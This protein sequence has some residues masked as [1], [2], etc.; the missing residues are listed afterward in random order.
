MIERPGP[1]PAAAVR[2]PDLAAIEWLGGESMRTENPITAVVAQLRAQ[3]ARARRSVWARGPVVRWASALGVLAVLAALG[4][5]IASPSPGKYLGEGRQYP[6][7][8]LAEITRAL[9]SQQIEYRVEERRVGVAAA[10]YDE[11]MEAIAKLDIGHRSVG[12]IRKKKTHDSSSLWT[13]PAE[14]ERLELEAK[15]ETL[16]AM[17][18]D[19]DG[20]VSADV[21]IHRT[22]SR[23][24]LRPT[25]TSTAFVRLE[26]RDGRQLP[27]KTV[28]T[29]KDI[30]VANE[31]DLKP[32][33][34]TVC[35]RTG[36]RYLDAANPELNEASRIRA[37]EEELAQEMLEH[38]DWIKGVRVTVQL[39]TPPVSAPAPQPVPAAPPEETRPPADEPR[40]GVNQPLD[41]APEPDPVAAS[42]TPPPLLEK[43]TATPE[44]EPEPTYARVWVKVPRSY[45][46]KAH[47]GRNPSLEDLQPIQ[48]STERLIRTAA[49]YVLPRDM[50][51]VMI[52]TIPDDIAQ[53]DLLVPPA[54]PE[55]RRTPS[56]W[57]PAGVAAALAS[58][59][60]I[61]GLRLLASRRPRAEPAVE[62]AHG[63]FA[64][65][66]A[67][68]ETGPGPS[69]RVRELIRRNPEAAASVLHRW[70]GHGGHAA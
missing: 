46:Y 67:S 7:D 50:F 9:Q 57:V 66:V 11:A 32:D 5:L 13:T 52:D 14:K 40:V 59:L 34:V 4:Y 65:D 1:S 30:I 17:I 36:H 28:Q 6:V 35:D 31:P 39:V 62:P 25:S 26:T 21:L 27:D 69:E 43:P 37:R 53:R 56:W 38:L 29:I 47:P 44:P 24:G 8:D 18:S 42:S 49:N 60:L 20:V 33:A 55:T 23:A 68:D 64:R 3:L 12:E 70:I 48:A 61:A 22:Q 45:Y 16:E 63:T 10:R 54:V 2:S 51:L 41:L 15:E 19:L 58:A